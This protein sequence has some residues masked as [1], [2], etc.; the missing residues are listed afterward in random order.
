MF[1][2]GLG[3]KLLAEFLGTTVFLTGISRSANVLQVVLCLLGAILMSVKVSGAHLN[4]LVTC[5]KAVVENMAPLAVVGY[6]CAQILGAATASGL[7]RVLS[8]TNYNNPVD[9]GG[10]KRKVNEANYGQKFLGEMI[11]SMVFLSI[12]LASG[13]V[14]GVSGIPVPI[15]VIVGLYTG[16]T[17]ASHWSGGQLNP[18]VTVMQM[19]NNREGAGAGMVN[20]FGQFVGLGLGIGLLVLFGISSIGAKDTPIA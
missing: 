17:I 2:E 5:G 13:S 14:A 20:I 8:E 15:Q 1:P 11:G 9:L 16:A 19:I 10:G 3:N 6:I 4:P 12:V 18:A 7:A